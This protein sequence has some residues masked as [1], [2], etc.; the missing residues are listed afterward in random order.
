MRK[1]S[2]SALFCASTALIGVNSA[3]AQTQTQTV[4]EEPVAAAVDDI[5]VTAQ[6]RSQSVVD[7]PMSITAVSGEELATLG[8]TDVSDLV[9]ITPGLS[10]VESGA[11]VPVYS[12]RGV[13][14][15]DTS[16]GARPTVSVYVDEVPLP[17]SIMSSGASA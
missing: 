9:K 1:V 13:G 2:L 10:A 12:L 5:V 14:F 3:M 7:V 16:I 17:F 4:Q 6:R 11:A 15:F 8:V